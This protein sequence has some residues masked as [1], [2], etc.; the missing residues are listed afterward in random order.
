[1]ERLFVNFV[2]G[3]QEQ[4]QEPFLTTTH[5][6][7]GLFPSEEF[8]IQP[9]NSNSMR[10]LSSNKNECIQVSLTCGIIVAIIFLFFYCCFLKIG[11]IQ[12][13]RVETQNISVSN[14]IAVLLR[15]IC[16]MRL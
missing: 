10:R 3:A 1:M 6:P 9:D 4:N 15:N 12:F 14:L 7:F 16:Q 8:R 13:S 2:F 11:F 5:L